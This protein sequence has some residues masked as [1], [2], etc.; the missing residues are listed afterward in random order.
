MFSWYEDR[1]FPLLL[2]W[3]TRPLARD[4]AALIGSA[5]GRVL[6]LGVGNGANFPYYSDR[7]SEI[8]GIEPANALLEEA[9][10]AARE[11]SSP[12]RF[13]LI[14]AGAEALPYPDNHFDS[15]VACLVFCTIPDAESAARETLRV[16]KP[17]GALLVLEHVAHE[18]PAWRRGQKLIEPVW[19]PLACGCHLSRDTLSVFT[20]SGFDISNLKKWQHPKLPKLAGFMLS[21]TAVK[22]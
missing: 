10:S 6:E 19:T 15:V 17:G 12:E 5:S 11:T 18:K 21:G 4:R 7:A 22:P 1:V 9:R 13:H 2:D 14:Q 20:R 3:A 16:L 8:H